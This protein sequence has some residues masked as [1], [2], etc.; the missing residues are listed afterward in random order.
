MKWIIFTTTLIKTDLQFIIKI[1]SKTLNAWCKFKIY[2]V[3][4]L[5]LY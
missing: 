3:F 1:I 2:I 5:K 4:K